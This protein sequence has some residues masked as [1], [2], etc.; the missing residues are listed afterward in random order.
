MTALTTAG[1]YAI[2]RARASGTGHHA[3]H[4]IRS[5]PLQQTV[6]ALLEGHRLAEH[7]A[8]V[9]ASVYILH[10]AV[11]IIADEPFALTSGDMHELPRRRRSVVAIDDTVMLLTAVD[12]GA[13]AGSEGEGDGHELPL[14]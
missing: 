6:I 1:T 8:E 14:A 9:P 5:G 2:D 11:Q 12:T 10:G 7:E 3:H 13:D 4:V